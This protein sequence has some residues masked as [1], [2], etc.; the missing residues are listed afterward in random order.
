MRSCNLLK[1]QSDLSLD[2]QVLTELH[3][4]LI[5]HTPKWSNYY[6]MQEYSFEKKENVIP[7]IQNMKDIQELIAEKSHISLHPL[8]IPRKV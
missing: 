1:T 2:P 4:K 5:N 6:F 7:D 8:S 3:K